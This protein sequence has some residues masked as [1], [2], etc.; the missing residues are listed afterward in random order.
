MRLLVYG[1]T[2]YSERRRIGEWPDSIS[3]ALLQSRKGLSEQRTVFGVG[4]LD[5]SP[6]VILRGMQTHDRRGYPI[7][8]LLD[9]GD[10]WPGFGWNGAYL[11]HLLLVKF[12]EIG[13]ELLVQP[14]GINSTEN[15]ERLLGPCAQTPES[16]VDNDGSRSHERFLSFWTGALTLED[17]LVIGLQ[18]NNLG[19]EPYPGYKHM[20]VR[21]GLLPQPLR[22]AVG[23]VIGGDTD[24]SVAFNTKVVFDES[25]ESDP[26]SGAQI[27][28][29]VACGREWLEAWKNV[30]SKAADTPH[31]QLADLFLQPLLQW[32][33][34]HLAEF[35]GYTRRDLFGDLLCISKLLGRSEV[36]LGEVTFERIRKIV[37]GYE[38]SPLGPV[39]T[40]LLGN[41]ISR[42]TSAPSPVETEFL[43][44]QEFKGEYRTDNNN[45]HPRD[46]NSYQLHNETALEFL[47]TERVY[48][49]SNGRVPKGLQFELALKLLATEKEAVD[50]PTRLI[51]E[52][53]H[54]TG[55][56]RDRREQLV[57]A[58]VD[59][60]AQR[61]HGMYCWLRLWNDS[62]FGRELR[63][64]TRAVS[65][66]GVENKPPS[67]QGNYLLFAEDQSGNAL[68][69]QSSETVQSVIRNALHPEVVSEESS[70]F[71]KEHAREWL[72]A[73]GRSELRRRIPMND[74]IEIANAGFENWQGLR[75]LSAEFNR[76]D[77]EVSKLSLRPVDR[78][79]QA[80]LVSEL[81]ELVASYVS[82]S[83]T[84]TL[85]LRNVAAQFKFEQ[86][87]D[88]HNQFL[89]AIFPLTE[90]QSNLKSKNAGGWVEGW[91]ESAEKIL[92]SIEKARLIEK[93]RSEAVRYVLECEKS[94]PLKW[95][96]ELKDLIDEENQDHLNGL[97]SALL[98]EGPRDR[99]TPYVQRVADF[100]GELKSKEFRKAFHEAFK[101][102]LENDDGSIAVFWRRFGKFGVDKLKGLLSTAQREKLDQRKKDIL[103]ASVA[104]YT[105]VVEQLFRG[106]SPHRP[107]AQEFLE[108]W[109]DA[110]QESWLDARA[111]QDAVRIVFKQIAPDYQDVFTRGFADNDAAISKIREFLAEEDS[112]LEKMLDQ[113]EVDKFTAIIVSHLCSGRDASR[114]E[115]K[116][117][118]IEQGRKNSRL[119]TA[120][121][122]AVDKCLADPDGRDNFYQTFM[123]NREA[124]KLRIVDKT[125]SISLLNQL[126][127][128][129]EPGMQQR[130]IE[131]LLQKNSELFHEMV[132][133]G[134]NHFK[135][136]ASPNQPPFPKA[137]FVFLLT[138]SGKSSL[139]QLA[140]GLGVKSQVVKG[141]LSVFAKDAQHFQGE[142]QADSS[143]ETDKSEETEE[144]VGTWRQ[145]FRAFLGK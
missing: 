103:S 128:S 25:R 4:I 83:P 27:S 5:D 36:S 40:D 22:S 140:V 119:K 81:Q 19:L 95:S 145:L 96:F 98:F 8:L 55:L 56:Q 17:P 2:Q 74:K 3:S 117:L 88:E 26:N 44:H 35:N 7:T 136:R 12:S 84:R 99:D 28:D 45:N 70:A 143:K 120:T 9:P 42:S 109:A 66:E 60:T 142:S 89:K 118:M 97:V 87:S 101:T 134:F 124:V 1:G 71:V 91:R 48:P 58:A 50:V 73:I 133:R 33:Q 14:E 11:L 21:L 69:N 13:N 111:F 122:T 63:D 72:E 79:E 85:N 68:L 15:L 132:S 49:S 93:F 46:L 121:T 137:V 131:F 37:R 47:T 76:Q 113:Y 38:Q 135:K 116:D 39:I 23:W 107:P 104:K 102:R 6:F 61:P 129:V 18:S 112:G 138:P 10:L 106:I 59:R 30:E 125:D 80:F 94:E 16:A 53:Q 139:N 78:G 127:A 52:L 34:T 108:V 110:Q 32:E 90:L 130:L 144:V 31:K 141:K 62:M 54:F 51:E 114:K 43:L 64:V 57:R 41:Q 77:D 105:S 24:Y 67:W 65:L 29:L 82:N 86:I 92:I 100:G 75:V 20:A 123:L 115:L 126:F